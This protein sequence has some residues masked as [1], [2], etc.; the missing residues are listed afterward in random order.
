MSTAEKVIAI[1]KAEV[2]YHEGRSGNIWN[3]H[4]K[5]SSAVPGLE[6]SQNQAWCATFVSWVALKAGVASLYPRTASTD[7]AA[8][9]YKK[10][11][12]WSEYPAIGA[13]GFLGHG[14][15][16]HHTF[17][18]IG[19]DDEYVTTVEGNTNNNGSPQGDGVYSLRRHRRDASIAGYGYPKFPEGIDSAD[20]KFGRAKPTKG[21]PVKKP[22]KNLVE[23]ANAD[24]DAAKRA[25][26]AGLNKLKQAKANRKG[27]LVAASEKELTAVRNDLADALTRL[28]EK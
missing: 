21:K 28:P 26:N 15:D 6:W 11:G 8:A 19:M 16:M 23:Q 25:M 18:V 1:A 22:A 12:R 3:N 24:F 4:Q 5:Y 13:Q 2:G 9:W 14:N 27:P 7:A 17:F 20:P 10:A